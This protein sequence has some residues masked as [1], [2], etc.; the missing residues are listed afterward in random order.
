MSPDE[1]ADIPFDGLAA[2]Q[3]DAAARGALEGEAVDVIAQAAAGRRKRLLLADM[4]STIVTTETLDETR[5]LC[6][7]EGTHRRDHAPRR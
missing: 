2:E 7:A 4:D 3:A 5:R 1:A 6:R